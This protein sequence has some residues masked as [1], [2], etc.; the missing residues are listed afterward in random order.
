MA[1]KHKNH[2][3]TAPRR[4]GISNKIPAFKANA[5]AIGETN[6]ITA[7]MTRLWFSSVGSFIGCTCILQIPR[8]SVRSRESRGPGTFVR[9]N[10]CRFTSPFLHQLA[11]K[12]LLPARLKPWPFSLLAKSPKRRKLYFWNSLRGGRPSQRTRPV[13][14]MLLNSLL[15][16]PR[17]GHPSLTTVPARA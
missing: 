5:S 11:P 6:P 3:T 14:K 8:M 15:V 4:L 13:V 10:Y 16:R 12:K 9:N 7:H 1:H 17:D 2:D